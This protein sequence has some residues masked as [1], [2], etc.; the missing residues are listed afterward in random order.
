M[1]PMGMNYAAQLDC[2]MDVAKA[3]LHLHCNNDPVPI[4]T[5][6]AKAWRRTGGSPLLN[7]PPNFSGPARAFRARTF[8]AETHVS[9]LFQGTMTHMAPEVMLKGTCSKA[10]DVYA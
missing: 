9:S 4:L 7:C 10:S 5:L 8:D 2:A 6:L 3:M 1:T